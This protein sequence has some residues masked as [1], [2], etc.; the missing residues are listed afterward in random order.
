MIFKKYIIKEQKELYRHK[1]YLLSL[2]L[3]YD[4]IKKE[5]I[6]STFLD[7]NMELELIE[8]LKNNEFKYSIIEEDI[9]DV[10]KAITLR[11]KTLHLDSNNIFIIDKKIDEKVYF[12]NKTKNFIE[13]LDLQKAI[14]K[15]YKL[16]TKNKQES[17]S[18]NILEVLAQNS[19]D[20]KELFE[21]FAILENQNT[22]E[23]L[24]LEKLKK[25][26][27]FCISKIKDMQRDNFLCNCVPG[28][29]PETKFYIKANRVFSDYTNFFLSYEQEIKIWKYLF[30]N[31]NLVGV[32]KEPSL[33]EMFI[34]RKIY[35]IDEYGQKIKR[36][37]S[38]AYYSEENIVIYLSNGISSQRVLQEF[39]KEEL[40]QRVIEARD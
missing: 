2:D 8:F 24:Y 40:L 9:K 6:N 22:Q 21:I 38:K 37:I 20:F 16:T 35:T 25:F 3:E 4:A 28:F 17:F 11:Y 5:Y 30:K 19:E 36:V 18:I 32:F 7:F 12:L 34:G 10:K 13:I 33:Y 26:K 31:K 14:F 29:F 39:S 27:Y 15:S 1:A 23:L